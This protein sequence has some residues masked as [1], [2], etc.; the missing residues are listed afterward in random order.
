M[1]S[2]WENISGSSRQTR[3]VASHESENGQVDINTLPCIVY[4]KQAS[5]MRKRFLDSCHYWQVEHKKLDEETGKPVPVHADCTLPIDVCEGRFSEACYVERN[6]HLRLDAY[7]VYVPIAY[8]KQ[9]NEDIFRDCAVYIHG[10][11]NARIAYGMGT[12]ARKPQESTDELRKESR[13]FAKASLT[14]AFRVTGKT[15]DE[16]GDIVGRVDETYLST[17]NKKGERPRQTEFVDYI[18]PR[19]AK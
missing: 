6:A 17:R 13:A 2:S 10:L 5:K 3:L 18:G 11:G 9:W 7:E 19:P 4:I 12:L 14:R 15:M 1:S 8:A 16:N